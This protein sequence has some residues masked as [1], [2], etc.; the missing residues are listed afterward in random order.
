MV[1]HKLSKRNRRVVSLGK[2]RGVGGADK[3]ERRGGC[4]VD[5][6]YERRFFFKKVSTERK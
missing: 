5:V 1:E 3:S 2:R 4:S 6:T